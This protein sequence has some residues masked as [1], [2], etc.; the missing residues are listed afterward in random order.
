MYLYEKKELI[1]RNKEYSSIFEDKK[2]FKDQQITNFE[3]FL[4]SN[5]G[6]VNNPLLFSVRSGARQSMPGMMETVLNIGLTN[7][8][9]I[10]LINQTNNER[11]V[12]DSLR[13]LLMM[14]ADV[15]MEKAMGIKPKDGETIRERLEDIM[16]SE[17]KKNGI[18]TD[19]EL[20]FIK[21]D[22]PKTFQYTANEGKSS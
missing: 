12:Y 21:F 19:S 22:V 17:K 8:T 4:T 5:F 16:A 3:R 6:N 18:I 7:Q 10:G 20:F 1:E 2:Q 9:S 13:R 11:F 15:V 14:Y